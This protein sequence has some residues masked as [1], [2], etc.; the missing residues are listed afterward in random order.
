M[1]LLLRMNQRC[2]DSFWML[3]ARRTASV[4]LVNLSLYQT[5]DQMV[6]FALFTFMSLLLKSGMLPIKCTAFNGFYFSVTIVATT[7]SLFILQTHK[8]QRKGRIIT[9]RQHMKPYT[10]LP[11]IA[12]AFI[13]QTKHKHGHC[14]KTK[15]SPYLV[16]C[17]PNKDVDLCPFLK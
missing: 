10:V 9:R 13:R 6:F 7:I 8:I 5:A 2:S 4:W 11:V 12:H 17:P 16:T 14:Y 1:C 3:K 15:I